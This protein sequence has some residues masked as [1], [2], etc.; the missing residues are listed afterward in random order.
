MRRKHVVLA[1]T[2]S[3]RGRL[4]ARATNSYTQTHPLQ[5]HFARLAGRP[6]AQFLHA[7][8]AALIKSE[9]VVHKITVERYNAAGN[10]VLAKPCPICMLAIAAWGVKIVEHT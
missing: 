7:E 8:I 1:K 6:G 5:A 10:P 3:K 9:G 4:L 2:Y